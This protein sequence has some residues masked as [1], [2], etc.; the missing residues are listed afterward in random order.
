MSAAMLPLYGFS[1]HPLQTEDKKVQPYEHHQ[2]DAAVSGG[3]IRFNGMVSS[4][5]CV[6]NGGNGGE[7]F[8]VNLPTVST[9]HFTAAG[10][11]AGDTEFKISLTGCGAPGTKVRVNFQSGIMVDGSSGRL[12]VNDGNANAAQ[13]VQI[14]LAGRDNNAPVVIGSDQ[15]AARYFPV[16]ENGHVEMVYV[17]RY[18]ATGKVA[19]GHVNSHVTYVLQYQ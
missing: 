4:P 7:N 1:Q 5:T 14:E 19:P 3:V 2:K 16:D 11:T 9:G 13:N 17:A 10:K 15:K 18:Y 12:N 6:I 8:V